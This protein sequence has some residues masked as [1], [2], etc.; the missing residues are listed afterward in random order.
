VAEGT[1]KLGGA[2]PQSRSRG[3][4]MASSFAVA[5]SFAGSGAQSFAEVIGNQAG[6]YDKLL[7][8]QTMGRMVH[9]GKRRSHRS[10][11]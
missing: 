2:R 7:H 10:S 1:R 8:A 3:K 9:Q 5:S 6:A 4:T 11:K